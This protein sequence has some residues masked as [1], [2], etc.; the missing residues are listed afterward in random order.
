[1]RRSSW[2]SSLKRS[3]H[4]TLDAS[5]SGWG[6]LRKLT[7]SPPVRCD[8]PWKPTLL[9]LRM[10][11]GTS[12]LFR[13]CGRGAGCPR[14]SR[15][16]PA[17]PTVYSGFELIRG[18]GVG[19]VRLALCVRFTMIRNRFLA[20]ILALKRMFQS[21]R[22][23][24]IRYAGPSPQLAPSTNGNIPSRRWLSFLMKVPSSLLG[25][26]KQRYSRCRADANSCV[27]PFRGVAAAFNN[28]AQDSRRFASGSRHMTFSWPYASRT[29]ASHLCFAGLNACDIGR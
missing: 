26:S 15:R 27:R 12:T 19:N 4:S 25:A 18:I 2:L 21:G 17:G 6:A 14:N 20:T 7:C 28:N 24:S 5:T 29:T 8:G 10:R 9:H 3:R 1:M 23:S 22:S 16:R 13:R 11:V